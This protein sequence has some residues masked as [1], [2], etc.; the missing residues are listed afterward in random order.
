MKFN[1]YKEV[2]IM[3]I[4]FDEDDEHLFDGLEE[5]EEP[6]VVNEPITLK[7]PRV[8]TS[9]PLESANWENVINLMTSQ[10]KLIT[11]KLNA[12]EGSVPDLQ[13]LITKANNTI[14]KLIEASAKPIEEGLEE[15]E[16]PLTMPPTQ[17]KR[18]GV[19]WK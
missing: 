4:D 16:E 9:N 18:S 2:L 7:P 15:E 12:L 6:I 14:D 11:D 13:A 3:T 19:R 1:T 5:P 10:N 17:A 8:V